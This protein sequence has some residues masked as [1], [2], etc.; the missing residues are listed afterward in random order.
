VAV[1]SEHI[2]NDQ[3]VLVAVRG[4][5]CTRHDTTS[6]IL[7]SSDERSTGTMSVLSFL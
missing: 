4:M 1:D 6:T 2:L 5:P 7:N 3:L